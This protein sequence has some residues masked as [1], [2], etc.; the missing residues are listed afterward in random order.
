MGYAIYP[1]TGPLERIREEEMKS[2]SK[3]LAEISTP[4]ESEL[5][6]LLD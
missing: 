6:E 2:D 4:T 3:K 1:Q 5:K